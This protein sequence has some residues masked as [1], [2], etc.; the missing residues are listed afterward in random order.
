MSNFLDVSLTYKNIEELKR[1]VMINKTE[2]I[3]NVT[4]LVYFVAIKER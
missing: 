2:K 1:P 3:I 4:I